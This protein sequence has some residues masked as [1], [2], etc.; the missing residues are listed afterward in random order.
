M[1]ALPPLLPVPD[2]H[3]RLQTI[4]PEGTENRNYVTVVWTRVAEVALL[5]TLETPLA[6][7]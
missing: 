3:E 1:M 7:L 4:F 6:P 2:I 5:G